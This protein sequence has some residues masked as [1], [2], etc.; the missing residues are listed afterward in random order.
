MKNK[1]GQNVPETGSGAATFIGIL[2]IIIIFYILFLPPGERDKLLE[3]KTDEYGNIIEEGENI[4]LLTENIGRLDYRKLDEFEHSIPSFTL[5]KTTDSEVLKK[6]NPFYIKNGW[7]DKKFYNITFQ[8]EDLEQIDNILLSFTATKHKGMLTIKLN[9]NIIFESE[10]RSSNVEPIVLS[11]DTLQNDNNLEFGV[12]GVGWRFWT[13]NEYE[14]QNVQITGDITDI[15][16]QESR[17]V[18]HATE[19]EAINTEKA[20]LKF[21]PECNP[22]DV[23]ILDIT[24]NSRNIFSGI[25]DCGILN[26]VEFSPDFIYGGSN[27][28]VFKTNEGSY[29]I[30]QIQVK[31]ELK[32][33]ISPVYYFDVNSTIFNGVDS[34]NM[35]A[36]L[37]IRFV[38]DDTTKKLDLNIN[39]H[40]L[41]RIDQEK[42]YYERKLINSG[43]KKEIKQGNNYIELI[44]K[45]VLNIVELRVEV[46]EED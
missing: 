34:G 18:F 43:E 12:S 9:G 23:G 16:R 4:T 36:Y 19:T 32:E 41:P 24:I 10:L 30:D 28:V 2:I 42:P 29:L 15:S 14:L 35:S 21:N 7:F 3:E 5:F 45:S 20:T 27:K 26:I 17:N 38:D 13:T 33:K 11:K 8:I 37:K 31:T 46:F 22:R 1:K 40:K 44:P 6:I 39:D 25:P